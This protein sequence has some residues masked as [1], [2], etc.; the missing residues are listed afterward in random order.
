MGRSG[1]AS[2]GHVPCHS[3]V[4]LMWVQVEEQRAMYTKRIRDLEAR[5]KV[6]G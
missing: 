4:P 3:C 6:W 5:L 1:R 2:G